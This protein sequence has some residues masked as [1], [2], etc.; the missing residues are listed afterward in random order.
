MSDDPLFLLRGALERAA[1][2]SRRMRCNV[3]V[4][5]EACGGF[6]VTEMLPV[7]EQRLS[8]LRVRIDGVVEVGASRRRLGTLKE[9]GL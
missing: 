5:A 1:E 4:Y 9:L 6:T 8:W 2:R 7:A 3:H